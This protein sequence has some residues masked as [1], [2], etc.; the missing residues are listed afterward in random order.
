MKNWSLSFYYEEYSRS[1]FKRRR[2][3][4]KV[5]HWFSYSGMSYTTTS[6]Y[7]KCKLIEK[8]PYY[9][10]KG[11]YFEIYFISPLLYSRM[12]THKNYL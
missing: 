9:K 11:I 3:L 4:L 5:V 8:Y 7:P 2:I 1:N 10:P 6:I 12:H